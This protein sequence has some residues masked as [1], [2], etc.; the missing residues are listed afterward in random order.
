MC[1]DWVGV[2]CASW[3]AFAGSTLVGC[4]SSSMG[5]KGNGYEVY[6]RLEIGGMTRWVG[7]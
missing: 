1:S 3:W 5:Y 4:M 2:A 7:C 6:F